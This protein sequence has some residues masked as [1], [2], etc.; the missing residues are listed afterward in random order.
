MANE[1]VRFREPVPGEE[2]EHAYE[3]ERPKGVVIVRRELSRHLAESGFLSKYEAETI[4]EAVGKSDAAANEIMDLVLRHRGF[5]SLGEGQ[6][7]EVVLKAIERDSGAAQVLMSNPEAFFKM[8][9]SKK[10]GEAL[11]VAI[12]RHDRCKAYFLSHYRNKFYKMRVAQE[13]YLSIDPFDQ[14]TPRFAN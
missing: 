11:H 13:V 2:E 4:V 1:I 3:E 14:V 7:G 9:G 8:L 5:A 12:F 10:M 6:L